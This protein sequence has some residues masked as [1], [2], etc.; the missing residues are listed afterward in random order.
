MYP[1][2]HSASGLL[3]A[4]F[5]NHNSAILSPV[6]TV[7]EKCDSL[8]FVRQCGQAITDGVV[9]LW[10]CCMLWI[11]PQINRQHSN[12]S[13]RQIVYFPSHSLT[14]FDVFKAGMAMGPVFVTQPNASMKNI[15]L[16]TITT[17]ISQHKILQRPLAANVKSN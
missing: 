12:W 3:N 7:A 9:K 4:A 5:L 15:L 2:P 10:V 13:K 17:V 1:P 6:H 8:T 16:H 11:A 14:D